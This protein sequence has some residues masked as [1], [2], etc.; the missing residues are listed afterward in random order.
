M[1][2]I[3]V[4]CLAVLMLTAAG[5]GVDD[6]SEAAQDFIPDLGDITSDVHKEQIEKEPTQS[7]TA[8]PETPNESTSEPEPVVPSPEPERETPEENITQGNNEQIIP[9][10]NELKTLLEEEI[11][12]FDG[13]WSVYFKRLDNSAS[14]AISDGPKVAASLVKL[15]VAGAYFDAVD[16]G[17][18]SDDYTSDLSIMITDSSNEGC[19]RIIDALGMKAVTDF[20]S[21]IGCTDTQLNRKMLQVSELENYTSVTDCGEILEAVING[22]FVT[23]ESSEILLEL[24]K[25]QSRTWKIPAG[26][27]DGIETANKTGELADVE[28]DVS[29][30]WSPE[31]TYILCIMV[32]DVSSPGITQGNI[33]YV[34]KLVYEYLNQ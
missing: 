1:K 32:E 11:A 24:L 26:V 10:E 9:S 31:C 7:D 13:S 33:A 6:V 8:A 21:S 4:I 27:P 17:V 3:C 25:K 19:N 22:T 16:K 2:R 18:I 20:A 15:F 23:E 28:N 34:S 30:I 12:Q 5:C 14:F 29:V